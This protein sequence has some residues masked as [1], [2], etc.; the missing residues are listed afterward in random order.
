[1][2]FSQVQQSALF[3][4]GCGMQ[5]AQTGRGWECGLGSGGGGGVGVFGGEG[6]ERQRSG[7]DIRFPMLFLW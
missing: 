5:D 4:L 7:V 3:H 1:M 6:V 2:H